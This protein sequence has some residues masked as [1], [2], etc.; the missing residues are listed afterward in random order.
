[1]T[2]NEIALKTG[3]PKDYLLQTLG[4][5]GKVDPRLPLREWMHE[6]GKSVQ[7]VREA[8]KQYRAGK[9]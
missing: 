6:H 1:M 8:V 4:I 5:T 7:D 3:M 2:L 9:R